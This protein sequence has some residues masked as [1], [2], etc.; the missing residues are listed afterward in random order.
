M[1]Q[2]VKN[3]LWTLVFASSLSAAASSA[4][5]FDDSRATDVIAFAAAALPQLRGA[6]ISDLAALR[7]TRTPRKCTPVALQVDERD[8]LYRWALDAG[9]HPVIDDPP[10]IVDDNDVFFLRAADAGDAGADPPLPLHRRTATL[11]IRDPLDDRSGRLHLIESVSPP[12]GGPFT[13]VDYDP[14]ANLF[15][16]HTV[17]FGFTDGIPQT[18]AL[19]QQ[20]GLGPD[21]LD[22]IKVR[23]SADLLWSLLRF[24]RDES[25]LTT[26]VTGW[27]RGSLRATRHQE[28]RV[29][30]GWGIRSPRFSTYTF[31]YPDFAELPVSL[32]LA[33][34]PAALFGDIRIEVVLDFV[35]LQGWTLVRPGHPP[36]R[37]GSGLPPALDGAAGDW[38]ALRGDDATLL[39]VL[40]V[41]ASLDGTR[42]RLVY[43]EGN[44]PNPPEEVA[45]EQPA[46]GYRIDRW[47]GVEAGDHHLRARAFALPPDV[48]VAKFVEGLRQPL[49]VLVVTALPDEEGLNPDGGRGT[50]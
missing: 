23:A 16:G 22:R 48:D 1:P 24:A 3:C 8:A 50:P 42:R 46:V 41:S 15:R 28:Q 13:E 44:R 43:R 7:C 27:R 37:I 12:G 9:P 34:R 36:H 5:P 2:S 29:R 6:R 38:F 40:D 26:E 39:Q 33:H 10:G 21:L 31:F 35:E 19:R 49:V 32:R 30:I 45:G 47:D 17:A 25:D 18:L 20:G 4:S 11:E 14:L